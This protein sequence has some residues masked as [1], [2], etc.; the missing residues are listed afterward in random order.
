H[1]ALRQIKKD[2]SVHGRGLALAGL[3]IGYVILGLFIVPTMLWVSYVSLEVPMEVIELKSFP[4][5]DTEG[6]ITQSGVTIDRKIS[7]D[8]NGSLRI[9]A[10]ELTT[11]RLF[12]TGNIDIESARLIY[13]A[14]LRTE[15][16][17][18]QRK[19]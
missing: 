4:L 7:S 13:Q 5:D 15:D 16:V 8:G 11:I 6:L 1:I 12:E 2:S 19:T 3:I 9:E 18:G 10:A 14:R 17:E